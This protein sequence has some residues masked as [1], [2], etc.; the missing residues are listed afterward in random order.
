MRGTCS[1]NHEK[2]TQG[3]K[4]TVEWHLTGKDNTFAGAYDTQASSVTPSPQTQKGKTPHADSWHA[5][6]MRE[7]KPNPLLA[8]VAKNPWA[9]CQAKKN[10]AADADLEDIMNAAH[11]NM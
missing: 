8:K 1:R 4:E 2:R 7:S 11:V 9:V 10:T 3:T 5:L 6:I